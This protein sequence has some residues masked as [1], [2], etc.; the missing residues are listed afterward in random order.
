MLADLQAY[1]E[2]IYRANCGEIV[3]DYLVTDRVV[4]NSLSDMPIARGVEETV[5]LSQKGDGIEMS[6]FLDDALLDRL[7]KK[8]PI[9]SISPDALSDLAIVVEG[10]SHFH[11]I[12]WCAK[13]GRKVTMLEL[14]LQA[15]VDKFVTTSLIAM[16]Q[17]ER[18]LASNLHRLLFSKVTYRDTLSHHEK[19]RYR[20][21]NDYA[22]R[23]CHRLRAR[24]GS[25]RALRE[26]RYFYRL[27][28]SQ[29]LSHIRALAWS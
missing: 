1:L 23:F 29:K 20:F 27:T 10:I 24:L 26:L 22:A 19:E 13:T 17:E 2:R 15:E 18:D 25:Q 6:V 8:D 21:A 3:S 14:E 16:Q 11:L 4:A 5:L 7:E 12:A 28:Q 9:N